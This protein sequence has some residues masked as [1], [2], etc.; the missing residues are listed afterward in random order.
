MT[1]EQ[2]LKKLKTQFYVKLCRC[3]VNMEYG[4]L[5]TPEVEHIFTK[6]IELCFLNKQYAGLHMYVDCFYL[7]LC[8]VLK[9]NEVREQK[10]VFSPECYKYI[11]KEIE[12]FRNNMYRL[13][14][15]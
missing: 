10:I 13:M 12:I 7:R 3:S 8:L 2:E 4:E 15:D 9:D 5:V 1:K 14:N 6:K 11:L